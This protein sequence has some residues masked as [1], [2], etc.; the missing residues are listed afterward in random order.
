MRVILLDSGVPSAAPMHASIESS[1]LISLKSSV[2]HVLGNLPDEARPLQIFSI[3]ISLSQD[4]L[5]IGP[6]FQL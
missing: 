5:S 3:M 4:G 2:V 1:M 6:C